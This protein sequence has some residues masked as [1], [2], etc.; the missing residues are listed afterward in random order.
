MM[1]NNKNTGFCNKK[2]EMT[3]IK[4]SAMVVIGYVVGITQNGRRIQ[5][6]KTTIYVKLIINPYQ[7]VILAFIFSFSFFFF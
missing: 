7:S 5:E 6:M 1:C 2:Q 4:A 3:Q